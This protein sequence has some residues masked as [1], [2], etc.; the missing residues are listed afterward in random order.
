MTT[1]TTIRPPAATARIK[2]SG[3]FS[4]WLFIPQTGQRGKCCAKG[5]RHDDPVYQGTRQGVRAGDTARWGIA[6]GRT[7]MRNLGGL[8]IWLRIC[9]AFGVLRGVQPLQM[10]TPSRCTAL[11]GGLHGSTKPG[12]D[13]RG[14]RCDGPLAIRPVCIT[15]PIAA[16]YDRK[17]RA[18]APTCPRPS[19]ETLR[20]WKRDQY[21]P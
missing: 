16:R 4:R 11:W 5:W 18:P 10:P 3:R 1:W 9:V 12:L 7:Q 2:G 20:R 14:R 19:R 6:G 13:T 17:H 8:S 15:L 21:A